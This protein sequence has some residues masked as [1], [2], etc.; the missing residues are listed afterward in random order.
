MDVNSMFSY[1]KSLL[2]SLV[3]P[4]QILDAASRELR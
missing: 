3:H 4:D 2:G 1:P